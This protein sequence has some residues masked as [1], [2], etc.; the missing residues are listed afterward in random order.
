MCHVVTRSTPRVLLI[1]HSA[2]LRRRYAASLQ[3]QGFC[4]L[5]A[6]TAAEA[7][8]LAAELPPAAVVSDVQ[9]ACGESGLRLT[10][11]LKQADGLRDVPVVI[12]SGGLGHDREAAARAG[13]DRFLPDTVQPDALSRIVAGL[14][15]R[16]TPLLG[17]PAR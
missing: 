7:R 16:H 2:R 17:D 9:L 12:L 14:I 10:R 15:D 11:Q 13:C 1:G 6:C 4:T 8:R 5:Q 3:R